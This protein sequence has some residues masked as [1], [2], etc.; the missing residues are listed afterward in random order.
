[1]RLPLSRTDRH[2]GFLGQGR[3]YYQNV[4][5]VELFATMS[6]DVAAISHL[7]AYSHA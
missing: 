6:A 4:G 2:I 1:M 7:L 5:L 3:L